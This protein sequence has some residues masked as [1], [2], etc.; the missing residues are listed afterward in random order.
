MHAQFSITAA[1]PSKHKNIS[2][3]NLVFTIR[4][5]E[6]LEQIFVATTERPELFLDWEPA[7]AAS[8]YC[9][10]EIGMS[11]TRRHSAEYHRYMIQLLPI[12]LLL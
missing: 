3:Y 8:F 2:L 11:W 12:M 1:R 6:S 5:S 7:R 9:Q 4:V 10:I